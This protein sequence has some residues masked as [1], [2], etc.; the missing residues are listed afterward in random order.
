MTSDS[1]NYSNLKSFFKEENYALKAYTKS[2][3]NYTADCDAYDIVQDVALKIFSRAA[4]ASQIANIAGFFY[5]AIQNKVVVLIR[6][7]KRP[8]ASMTKWNS[9]HSVR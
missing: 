5:R 3:I 9:T 2:R 1:E 7:K 4:S 8:R 6:T